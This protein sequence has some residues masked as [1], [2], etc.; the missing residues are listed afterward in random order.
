MGSWR[1][2]GMRLGSTEG[3]LV[4]GDVSEKQG[5]EFV[6]GLFK[7]GKLDKAINIALE[8]HDDLG[9][10][11]SLETGRVPCRNQERIR[12]RR[13]G[14]VYQGLILGLSSACRLNQKLKVILFTCFTGAELQSWKANVF[15]NQ[16]LRF[17]SGCF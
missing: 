17:P 5:W 10:V 13:Q 14:C 11:I 15:K 8:H 4:R 3:P 12:A 16:N 9:A 7:Y 2:R 6:G 1:A